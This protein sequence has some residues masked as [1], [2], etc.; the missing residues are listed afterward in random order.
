MIE[1]LL[2]IPTVLLV[3]NIETFKS[4]FAII[5][6]IW[7]WLVSRALPKLVCDCIITKSVGETV[8]GSKIP[9]TLNEN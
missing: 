2:W 5:P 3:I 7:T 9:S 6:V 8:G 1:A 4:V